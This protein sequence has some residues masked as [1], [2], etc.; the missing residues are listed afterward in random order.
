MAGAAAGGVDQRLL[1][2]R[3]HRLQQLPG[4]HVGHAEPAG[5]L[6]EGA[7]LVDRLEEVDLAGPE[8]DLVAVEDP[9]A[10]ADGV[11]GEDLIQLRD[12]IGS[13]DPGKTWRGRPTGDPRTL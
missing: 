1:E 4:A 11:H 13:S 6:G 10:R 5:G 12:R 8:G 9:Q 3:V 7:G 2:A